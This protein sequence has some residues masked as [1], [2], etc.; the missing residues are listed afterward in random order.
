MTMRRARSCGGFTVVE[1]L[2]VMAIVAVLASL[3]AP[4]FAELFA[5]RRLE[6]AATDLS[7]D[8]HFARSQAVSDRGAVSLVTGGG[9]TQYTITGGAGVLKTVTL[10]AN[11]TATDA[12]T[13]VYDPL[14][15]ML[16]GAAQ[17]IGLASTRTAATLQVSVNTMGRVNLCSPGASLK[18]YASC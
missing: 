13:V 6:G 16:T 1:L 10:P 11:V 3:A 5:R 4:S 14:R 2:V 8:L 12:V 7:T 18:G 17:Q 15:G 9:G